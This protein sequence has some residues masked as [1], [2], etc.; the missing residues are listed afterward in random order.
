VRQRE[1]R[2]RWAGQRCRSLD[3]D[4]FVL[5]SSTTALCG[6][7]KLGR[8]DAANA[9]LDTFAY[10]RRAAGRPVTSDRGDPGPARRTRPFLALMHAP[11]ARTQGQPERSSLQN[12]LAHARPEDR[13]AAVLAFVRDAV[14]RTLGLGQHRSVDP[15]QGLFE[16]GMDSLMSVELKGRLETAVGHP[17]PTTLTFNY[18]N[19]AA[20]AGF[21]LS[22]IDAPVEEPENE[23]SEEDLAE[24]LAARL[25]GLVRG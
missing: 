5:F 18:P 20:L 11:T 8:Y 19:V 21:L 14:V 24:L 4:F 16:M 13:E 12:A 2:R 17:L 15:D 23:R 10:A 9:F 6:S 25:A 7:S 3:L 22:E 1:A